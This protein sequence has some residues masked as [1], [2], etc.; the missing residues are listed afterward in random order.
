LSG[1]RLAGSLTTA[2]L[3]VDYTFLWT[4]AD[5]RMD[6]MCAALGWAGVA[7][8]LALRET[9]WTLALLLANSFL[10]LSLFTHPNAV[11]PLLT[12]ICLLIYFDGRRVSWPDLGLLTPYLVLA[13]LWG[14]YILE[15]PD[16]FL[17]Q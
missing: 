17:A 7:W 2:F 15:R 4:A 6:M 5:G 11:M 14:A 1:S 16:Y 13:V 3:A 9:R 8:Y 10:A 12:F